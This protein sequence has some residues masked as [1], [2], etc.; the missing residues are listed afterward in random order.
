MDSPTLG[1]SL[2]TAVKSHLMSDVPYGVLLSGGL[3]SSLISAIAKKFADKRVENDGQTGAWGPQLHSFAVGLDGSPDLENAQK[4]ADA[5]GTVHHE[6]RFT[7]QQGI[8]ALREVILQ[9]RDLRRDNDSRVDPHVVDGPQDQSH[10]NQN[11]AFG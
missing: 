6:I 5:I 8:D 3:D 10:G 4:V 7:V 9:Y 2:E 1:E 11:G